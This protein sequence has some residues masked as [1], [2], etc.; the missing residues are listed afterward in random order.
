MKK[1]LILL[2]ALV[3]VASFTIS[4]HA[5]GLLGIWPG[6]APAF[7]GGPGA[8]GPPG[9]RLFEPPTFYVGWMESNRKVSW[10][11]NSPNSASLFGGAHSWTPSGLWL[12]LEQKINLT[13]NCGLE[14]DGWVLIPSNRR[15]DEQETSVRSI[16]TRVV[17]DE[18]NPRQRRRRFRKSL[19]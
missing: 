3:I 7:G 1:V 2:A 13:E 19:N 18:D 15:G 12:G 8:Y 11:F 17:G 16:L 4:G 5:Q 6:S 9:A 10:G 14:L